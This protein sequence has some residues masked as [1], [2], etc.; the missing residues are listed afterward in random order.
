MEP[1][2]TLVYRV[3]FENG[4]FLL[5]RRNF[6][7]VLGAILRG[8]APEGGADTLGEKTDDGISPDFDATGVYAV[9]DARHWLTHLDFE[10]RY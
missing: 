7:A 4:V 8:Y 9:R 5:T 10:D 1:L 3:R 6:R 2:K